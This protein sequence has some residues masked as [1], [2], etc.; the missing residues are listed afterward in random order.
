V[1]SPMTSPFSCWAIWAAVKDMMKDG[2]LQVLDPDHTLALDAPH[3]Q[4]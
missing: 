1:P 3:L 4:P 2:D